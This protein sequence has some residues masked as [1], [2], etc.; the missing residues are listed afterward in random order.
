MLGRVDPR[1]ERAGPRHRRV[2]RACHAVS[3]EPHTGPRRPK[4]GRRSH[5][6]T[7]AQR[8]AFIALT[9]VFF[10]LAGLL[11]VACDRIIGP[12]PVEE[13]R[14]RDGRASRWRGMSYD[15]ALGLILAVAA[16]RV[17]RVRPHVPGEAVMT[18]QAGSNFSS[19]SALIFVVHAAA[20]QLHGEG[21]ARRQ[22]ARRPRLRPVERGIYRSAASTPRASS[23]GR[24]TRSRCSPSAR[25]RCSS[26]TGSSACSRTCRS[27][28]TTSPRSTPTSRGTP[29]SA[30]SRTRTGRATAASRR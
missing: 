18:P 8:L 19:S 21:V 29:R 23:A 6:R 7:R 1:Q 30:S 5:G 10:V 15:N 26:S 11:T 3:G 28:P 22:G 12:D 2:K 20:R 14:G 27:T 17:P 16:D 4:C 9:I 13:R 24:S 25:S